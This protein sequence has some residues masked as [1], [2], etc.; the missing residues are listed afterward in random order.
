LTR[1]PQT[2]AGRLTAMRRLV[3]TWPQP[4]R[5][6]VADVITADLIEQDLMPEITK[7]LGS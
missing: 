4:F 5:D 3:A 6:Q 2:R 7:H 1:P